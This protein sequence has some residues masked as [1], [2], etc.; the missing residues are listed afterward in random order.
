MT[1]KGLT[2]EDFLNYKKPSMFISSSKCTWK[3]VDENGKCVCQNLPLAKQPEK[4]VADRIIVERYLSNP[5]TKAIVIGGLEPFDQANE[6]L[7]LVKEL[8]DH[9]MDDIVVY[10]GYAK[11]EIQEQLN[12]LI[13]IARCNLIVKFGRY[14]PNMKPIYD[15][16]L[17]VTLGSDN[18]YAERFDVT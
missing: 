13:N 5:I 1:I 2:D 10:T 11:H 18:Q 7:D 12:N 6:L 17:G 15:S 16:V 4:T 8:R 14:I 3:C 9:T